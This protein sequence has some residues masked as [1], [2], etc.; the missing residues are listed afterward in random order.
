MKGYLGQTPV[1]VKDTKYKDYTPADWA[2]EFISRYGQIDGSHHKLWVLDQV[3][4]ILKGTPIVIEVAKW[5]NGY[6]EYRFWTGDESKEYTNW[7]NEMI[8]DKDGE[9]EYGYDEG[10][11]P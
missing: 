6:E 11:A 10:I 9:P 1:D 8:G 2:M 3:A 7:V 5:D 4:R